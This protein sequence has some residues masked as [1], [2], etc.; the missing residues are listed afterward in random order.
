[1]SRQNHTHT[2]DASHLH[3]RM[4][5]RWCACILM[6]LAFAAPGLAQSPPIWSAADFVESLDGI[7]LFRYG[8]LGQG[9][10]P[11][12][13]AIPAGTMRVTYQGVPLRSR[14]P[15][16]LD[17]DLIPAAFVDSVTFD[18]FN[19]LT[20]SLADSIPDEP[21]TDTRFLTG[22]RQRFNL[23]VLFRRAVGTQSAITFGGSSTGMSGHYP[24]DTDAFIP[25]YNFR[26]YLLDYY[27][28]L[29]SG[30]GLH[31]TL[32]GLR[33]RDEIAD[34]DSLRFMGERKTDEM[35]MSVMVSNMPVSSTTRVSPVLYY[36][37]SNSRFARYGPRK[38]LDE[39]VLGFSVTVDKT[40][41]DTSYRLRAFHERTYFSSRIHLDSWI[42]DES[43]I[44]GAF[45][46]RRGRFGIKL[47]GA[48][49]THSKYGT[50]ADISAELTH[51]QTDR[52][53]SFVRVRNASRYPGSGDEYYASLIFSDSTAVANLDRGESFS[54]EAGMHFPL[55]GGDG[56]IAGFYSDSNLPV[57]APA[58]A[59]MD[60]RNI[61]FTERPPYHSTIVFMSDKLETRGGRLRLKTGFDRWATWEIGSMTTVRFDRY[62]YQIWYYPKVESRF[63]G[64]VR[65]GFFDGKLGVVGYGTATLMHWLD[66]HGVKGY[67]SGTRFFLDAGL[68]IKVASLELFYQVENVTSEDIYWFNILQW[69]GRNTMYGGRWIFY[70]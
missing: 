18:S 15:F 44:E 14:S 69:Q 54:A 29:E 23:D 62:K 41:G 46:F 26:H 25:K 61:R 17:L 13:Q 21:L 47:D 38:S 32:R 56:E 28:E 30:A 20:F 70:Q 12:R 22:S 67:P 7:S 55:P 64:S 27:R 52:N 36:Q 9:A 39:N 6:F 57:F 19:T 10:Y 58:A 51:H 11:Y 34:L 48:I 2:G 31:V 59:A 1:M 65:R 40:L 66:E 49:R 35:T 24:P 53:Y 63:D 5:V 42:R 68:S 50:G 16:G 3:M 8:A 33:D 43:A 37:K 45:G 60:F 4:A